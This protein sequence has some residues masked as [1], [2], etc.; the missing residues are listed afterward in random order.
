MAHR[1]RFCRI[2][3]EPSCRSVPQVPTTSHVNRRQKKE[4]DDHQTSSLSAEIWDYARSLFWWREKN[5]WICASRGGICSMR[6]NR[7]LPYT[8]RWVLVALEKTSS[9]VPSLRRGSPSSSAVQDRC[10]R[11]WA[12]VLFPRNIPL[13][14]RYMGK[15]ASM[16]R[17]NNS[18]VRRLQNRYRFSDS[19]S[20]EICS[21]HIVWQQRIREWCFRL[22]SDQRWTMCCFAL[23]CLKEKDD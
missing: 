20:S 9:C 13:F 23:R 22:D 2:T 10:R 1:I 19:E 6:R 16:T 14:L 3:E 7:G 18:S 11:G 4:P 17:G 8:S 15:R 12:L 5:I 21:Q